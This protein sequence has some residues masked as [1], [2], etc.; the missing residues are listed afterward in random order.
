MQKHYLIAI[1]AAAAM[2]TSSAQDMQRRAV[3]GHG[4]GG[5]EGCTLTVMVDGITDVEI[6]GDNATLRDISGRPSQIREFE[7]SRPIPPNATV[8]FTA[9]SGRG[10]QE[11]VHQG[12]E[13]GALVVHIED[14]ESGVGEYRF[15]LTWGDM[16]ERR[17]QGVMDRDR[18]AGSREGDYVQERE[19]FFQGEAWR[20]SLFQRVREDVEHVERSA[21]PFTGDRAR[22]SRTITELN[23]LQGKLSEGRYDERQL[24]DV[25]GALHTVVEENRLTG[26][27][28]DALSDDMRRLREFRERRDEYGARNPHN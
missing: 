9:E 8:R 1:A 18:D 5:G 26:P 19:R 27:D 15:R 16:G 12:S 2:G 17:E 28:R 21:I 24:D 25:I 11:M 7:C 22:L 20:R 4:P 6:R 14:P 3:L 23:E 10:R 13:G